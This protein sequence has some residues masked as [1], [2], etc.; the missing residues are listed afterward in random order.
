MQ[1]QFVRE[2]GKLL[3]YGG[4]CEQEK[5]KFTKDITYFGNNLLL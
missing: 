2:N 5:I 3:R 4:E 1:V